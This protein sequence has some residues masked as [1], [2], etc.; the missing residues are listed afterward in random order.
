[1]TKSTLLGASPQNRSLDLGLDLG[2]EEVFGSGALYLG[3]YLGLEEI[4]LLTVM[5]EGT[6][7][8][9]HRCKTA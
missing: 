3:L 2:L 7:K 6:T 8:H 1:M 5:R 9:P 4:V